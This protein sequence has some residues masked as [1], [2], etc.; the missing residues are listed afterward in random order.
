M[1]GPEVADPA[2]RLYGVPPPQLLEAPSSWLCRIALH[3]GEPLGALLQAL[4]LSSERCLDVQFC[5]EAERL[6]P[7]LGGIPERMALSVLILRRALQLGPAGHELLHTGEGAGAS[8]F[9]YCPECFG[10]QREPH[11]PVHWRLAP[12]IYCH[13]HQ[14]LLSEVCRH[15][16]S[17]SS[18]P[19]DLVKVS[20]Q[21]AQVAALSRCGRCGMELTDPVSALK[22]ARHSDIVRESDWRKIDN[23]RAVVAAL[24]RGYFECAGR[25]RALDTVSLRE[26]IRQRFLPGSWPSFRRHV[27]RTVSKVGPALGW[28]AAESEGRLLAHAEASQ[29]SVAACRRSKSAVRVQSSVRAARRGARAKCRR[30]K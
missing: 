11:V 4:G 5:A 25:T 20:R 29:H 28:I 10:C 9:R 1:S 3:Q 23:G 24:Q 8:G 17:P 13:V 27:E 19:V 2:W 18:L 7:H 12:W 26:L 22:L 14:C 30:A 15:C 21:G 16:G 6:S